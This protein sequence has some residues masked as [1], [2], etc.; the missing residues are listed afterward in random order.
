MIFVLCLLMIGTFIAG[1]AESLS[2]AVQDINA[3]KDE[4]RSLRGAG[5]ASES[6]LEQPIVFSGT[7]RKYVNSIFRFSSEE[8]I[9]LHLLILLL[10]ILGV[11][12][13]ILQQFMALVPF[14]SQR[15][16]SFSAA[17]I[18]TLMASVAGTVRMSALY[19]Q[20]LGRSV[21]FLGSSGL[22]NLFVIVIVLIFAYYAVSKILVMLQRSEQ[23]SNA[24]QI[25][26]DASF[27]RS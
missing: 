27:N 14:F 2:D 22:L 10:A 7:L 6:S 23:A 24:E 11:L 18:I 5:G 3:S 17:V 13:L 16:Q 21:Q 8:P 15:W 26:F 9:N 12:I 20:D 25:G 1:A 19:L 4:A